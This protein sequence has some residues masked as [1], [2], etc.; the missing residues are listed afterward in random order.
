MDILLSHSSE[1]T[2]D[3]TKSQWTIYQV[4][5]ILYT[6]DAT[7]FR[8]ALRVSLQLELHITLTIQSFALNWSQQRAAMIIF[9]DTP[10]RLYSDGAGD[11]RGKTTG[12]GVDIVYLLSI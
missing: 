5:R 6:Y 7:S 4:S 3:P 12:W 9:S 8:N 10:S 2:V 1:S 11:T